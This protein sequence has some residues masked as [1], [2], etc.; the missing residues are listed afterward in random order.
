MKFKRLIIGFVLVTGL[1]SSQRS[2]AADFCTPDL[3]GGSNYKRTYCKMQMNDEGD[4]HQEV[5]ETVAKQFDLK[6]D[7]VNAILDGVICEKVNEAGDQAAKDYTEEVLSACGTDGSTSVN[8]LFSQNLFTDVQNA[9]Y[10]ER[11][12]FFNKLSLKTKFE[13]SEK[14]WDGQIGGFT[15]APFDLVLDLNL[16][17]QVLFGSQATWLQDVY[18]F[19]TEEGDGDD[20]Q[21]LDNQLDLELDEDEDV[22]DD[23]VNQDDEAAADCVL[24]DDPDA[25]PNAIALLPLCGNGAVDILSGEACDDGN[26]TSGDGCNQFCQLENTGSSNLCQDPDAVTFK[27]P[28][29]QAQNQ[30]NID[31]LTDPTCPPG[32]VPKKEDTLGSLNTPQLDSY[33]GPA[34]GGTLKQFPDSERP[35]CGPG[36]TPVKITIAGQEQVALDGNGDPR[37]LPT[38]FCSDPDAARTFLAATTF[39]FPINGIAAAEWQQLPEDHAVRKALEAVDAL[40]C[41]DVVQNNRPTSPYNVNEGCIDCHLIAM[42]DSLEEALSTN[43]SP[44]ENTTSSFGLSSRFGP[45]MSFNLVTAVKPKFKLVP[46]QTAQKSVED[47]GEAVDESAEVFDP[48][49]TT[50]SPGGSGAQQLTQTQEQFVEQEKTFKENIEY[51]NTGMG[52]MSDFEV[53]DRVKPLIEQMS[54][55]FANIQST[56][57]GIAANSDLS[58]LDACRI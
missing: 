7:V 25:D 8:Q 52:A 46:T 15:D 41:V 1:L 43:V 35:I 28:S 3:T 36:T 58:D 2:Y 54:N 32:Y 44:L 9:F 10:K 31:D 5:L 17:E 14:Y 22:P 19:P 6:T 39:P 56:F 53:S 16:I 49:G 30:N 29:N 57:Q 55:S 13:A 12:I 48:P 34:V 26:L 27:S 11:A 47:A 21:N 51:Y 42:V 45:N 37:C 50:I 33:P 38:E 24:P 23:Q 18:H 4:A 40:F 20:E